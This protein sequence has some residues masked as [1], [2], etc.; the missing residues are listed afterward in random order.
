M[1]KCLGPLHSS[2]AR[3]K[4]GGLVINSWRGFSTVKAKHAPAQPRSSKQ[5]AA[6][7]IMVQA[8]RAWQSVADQASW[9]AYATT[10]TMTDWTNS[11]KRL[12]GAN[13]F[14]ML[15]VRLTRRGQ[16]ILPS[17]PTTVAP[18]PATSVSL[19][20]TALGFEV[21]WAPTTVAGINAEIWLDGPHSL[22]RLGSIQKA[23]Y[24]MDGD[25]TVGVANAAVPAAGH[26]TVY[27]RM[28][29]T[30]TGLV[31]QFISADG[32]TTLT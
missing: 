3:G 28:I 14:C 27:L 11:P 13:W 12:T 15:F 1:A 20:G 22:G 18:D 21:D 10:H 29:D 24:N 23:S 30:G 17:A 32:D 5:L 2:E 19:T 4:V 9:N 7:A 26:Y 8:S 31:S 16:L 6:R 25:G